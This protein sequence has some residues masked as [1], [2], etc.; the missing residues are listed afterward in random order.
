MGT[1][2]AI[3][4]IWAVVAAALL[5]LLL[6]V[7]VVAV[8]RQ[9]RL[10]ERTRSATDEIG[11]SATAAS[12]E[13]V[14]RQLSSG[15]AAALADLDE[16]ADPRQAVL[17]CWLRLEEAVARTGTARAPAETSAELARRVLTAYA[18]AAGRRWTA[19]TGCIRWRATRRHRC[20][21]RPRMRR[22]PHSA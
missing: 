6:A 4:A 20:R 1:S 18:V 9:L 7:A 14:R 11:D 17:A 19:C 22:E 10:A 3:N 2:F 21:R 12:E 8:V 5:A 16:S 13:S 15:V